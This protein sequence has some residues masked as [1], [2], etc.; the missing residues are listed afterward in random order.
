MH[1]G[2][3]DLDLAAVRAFVAIT[4]D[5][6]FS[7]AAARLGISQ[8]AISK[9]IAKLESVLGV[10]L[11][12]RRHGGA[13]LTSDG[14]AFLTHARVLVNTADQAVELLRSRRR[15]LRV[16]VLDT[17]VAPID[18]IRAFH[19]TVPDVNIEIITSDG[20]RSARDALARG[21]VDA[22]FCR[23]GGTPGEELVC[24][25][26]HLEPAHLLVGRDH[27]LAGLRQVEIA[28]LAGRT[29]WMPGN[30]T[31]SEWAEYH[32]LLSSE[33]GFRIDTTGPNFGYE[34][35]VSKIASGER[36]TSIVG[37]NVRIPWHPDTVRIPLVDPVPLYPW[38]MLHHRRNHHPALALL[39]QHIIGRHRPFDPRHQWLPAPDRAAFT[40]DPKRH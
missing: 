1:R 27:P 24:L 33:F 3:A 7:E 38:S 4:E 17:R 16:D 36:A 28:R 12:A 19:E 30:V 39:A 14:A 9:R 40:A 13:E 31:G 22:A 18:L 20:L 21:S 29:V 35:F 5:R 10:P 23:V 15:A 25:P 6:Y 2:E 26:A 32:D 11:F 37:E 8:Q 34:H